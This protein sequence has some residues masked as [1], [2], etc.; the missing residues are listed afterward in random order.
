MVNDLER[1]PA[2]KRKNVQLANV[3]DSSESQVSRLT[4]G[5]N[6]NKNVEIKS[7]NTFLHDRV[8]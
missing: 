4:L 7:N 1:E 2:Y 5:E 8:D 3:P 6:E